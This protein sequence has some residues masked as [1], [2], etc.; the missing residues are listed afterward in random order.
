MDRRPGDI[1]APATS[2]EKLKPLDKQIITVIPGTAST[3][4]E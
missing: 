4:H 1:F 2:V 3:H